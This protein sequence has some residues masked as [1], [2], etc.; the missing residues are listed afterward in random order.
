MLI[1]FK[2][3]IQDHSGDVHLR[4]HLTDYKPDPRGRIWGLFPGRQST[5]MPTEFAARVLTTALR[6]W[7][8][9]LWVQFSIA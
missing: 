5:N 7:L 2:S 8:L 6:S 3:R 1:G 4:Q 9:L